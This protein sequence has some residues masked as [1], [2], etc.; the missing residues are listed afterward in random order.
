MA[1][2]GLRNPSRF[3]WVRE[4]P[5]PFLLVVLLLAFVAFFPSG[6]LR[7]TSVPV[8]PSSGAPTP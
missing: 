6:H 4:E 3:E 8:A 2:D 7:L 1:S 5:G